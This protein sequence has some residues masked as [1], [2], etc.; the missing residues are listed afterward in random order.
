M[1]NEPLK[2]SIPKIKLIAD[3]RSTRVERCCMS[4]PQTSSATVCV[5]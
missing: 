5:S 2:K 1:Y 4:N 3:N